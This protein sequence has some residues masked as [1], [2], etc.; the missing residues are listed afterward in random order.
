[1]RR[2]IAIVLALT[3]AL[4]IGA[5]NGAGGQNTAPAATV[6]AA[7]EEAEPAAVKEEAVADTSETESDISEA[8]AGPMS[9]AEP[10][11][12]APDTSAAAPDENAAAPDANEA[13]PDANAA[14]PN[15]NAAAP[16][17]NAAAP[18]ANEATPDTNAAAPDANA[19]TPDANAA[20][21][22]EEPAET[23]KA[24]VEAKIPGIANRKP[25]AG[26][27]IS[28]KDIDP[29][30]IGQAENKEAGTGC[31]VLICKNGMR[32][33]LDVRGGG[34]ASR[35]S[36]LL[37]PLM[38]AQ[39]LHAI[40]LAGGSAYGLGTANGVMSYLEEQGIGY[41]TGYALVPLVA[42]SDIY[43]LSV[44]DPTVRP[45]PDMGY[46]AAKQ[47]FESP[48]YQDGNFGAGCG[49]SVGKIAGMKYSM[50]TG[51][52]SYAVQI[53][54]LKIGAIVVL[55]AL[56]D[57]YDWRTG[58]QIAGFLTEDQK[59]LRSTMDYLSS[60]SEVNENKFSGNTTL[61]VVVTNADFNK[62]QL[63]KI[64]GMAHDGYARSINPVHTSA[65]G[66]SIYAVSVGNV[67]ADQDLI[68][69]LGAEVVSEAI[70]RA[71]YGA[72]G[73]YGL[74]AAADLQ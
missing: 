47:A 29:L 17:A 3:M 39:I 20:A 9:G 65:D 27:E 49:A 19:A 37:N 7:T 15:A 13:A 53:G 61:A 5:C 23:E 66:D 38:S 30:L 63:C 56:G 10:N 52:G 1:M 40:V 68:G 57:V 16:D 67:A 64:A 18:D 50:K 69:S 33:G 2:K 54:D 43:D 32:A 28:I 59:S 11:A 60:L 8:E 36:Q 26:V 25:L 73:A 34:P 45:D 70:I 48:N 71:V 55:N 12:A 31:T 74:P 6:E 51:I 4:S 58:Q 14:A 24:S 42:Q 44:G 22:D 72:E 62:T 46:A 41:D 35:E 21:T